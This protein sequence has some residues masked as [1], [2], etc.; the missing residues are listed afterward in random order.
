MTQNARNIPLSRETI[1]RTALELA[2]REGVE[3][4]SM[5]KLAAELGK[6]AM[7]L[8][9]YY[10][11]ADD[12]CAAA[13][14]LAFEEVD[15]APIPG[16]RWDETIRRTT[17]SIRAMYLRHL[18]AHFAYLQLSGDSAALR[19]HTERIYRL[20]A[21]QCIPPHVL[22]KAWRLLDAFLTGFLAN[23]TM[24]IETKLAHNSSSDE[25]WNDAVARAYSDEA[26]KDGID[27]I[28]SGITALA[29]PDPC[30]WRTPQ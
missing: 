30:D 27:I 10:D 3:N 12:I 2:D 7:A 14:A 11:S 23:E 26:F 25:I 18:H 20:H 15:T 29:A 19:D 4:V 21:A 13:V 17:A 28:I 1:A 6:T 24:E 5:R 9:R 22:E 8:Y 16:E